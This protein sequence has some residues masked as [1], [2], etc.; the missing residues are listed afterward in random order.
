MVNWKKLKKSIPSRVQA[1]KST[2]FEVVWVDDFKD[3]ITLGE[4]RLDTKQI[5][6]KKNM[7][8]KET[9]KVFGHEIV[10]MFSDINNLGLT[11]AQVTAIEEKVLY[12]VLKPGNI[13]TE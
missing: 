2:W 4:M 8:P 9:V 13:F 10:H 12:Y 7:S 3:G 1:N 11:E 5:V 6:L